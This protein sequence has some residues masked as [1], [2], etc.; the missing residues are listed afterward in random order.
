MKK[1]SISILSSVII[2]TFFML[3]VSCEKEDGNETNIS[4]YDA[5]ESHNTGEV[6]MQCHISG[7]DGEGWFTAAGSIYNLQSTIFPN[8]TVRFYTGQDGTGTLVKT[9]EADANGNFYTTEDINFGS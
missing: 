9:I 1:I 2:I 3:A 4:S 8:A 5:T 7:G 6:C